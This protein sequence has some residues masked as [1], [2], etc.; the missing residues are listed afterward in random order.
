MD[1]KLY[2]YTIFYWDPKEDPGETTLWAYSEED[3]EKRFYMTHRKSTPF[4]I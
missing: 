2:W 4:K 3:A 1:T